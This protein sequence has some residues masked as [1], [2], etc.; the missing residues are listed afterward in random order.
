MNVDNF[1]F[2]EGYWTS[3]YEPHPESNYEFYTEEVWPDEV[4]V[5][6]DGVRFHTPFGW[7]EEM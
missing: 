3:E 1:E 2:P 5:S 4:E 7:G 6:D